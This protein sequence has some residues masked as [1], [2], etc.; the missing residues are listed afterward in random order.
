MRGSA[1]AALMVV[2]G[3]AG[4]E[5]KPAEVA[6]GPQ[7]AGRAAAVLPTPAA[8]PA[9]ASPAPP[10]EKKPVVARPKAVPDTAPAL[11]SRVA[12]KDTEIGRLLD[13]QDMILALRA[14]RQAMDAGRAEWRNPDNGRRGEIVVGRQLMVNGDD[15]RAYSHTIFADSRKATVESSACRRDGRWNIEG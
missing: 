11:P 7:E 9:K 15:C 8:P 13:Q 2:V 1:I 14:E 5:S 12:L 10:V 6:A 4:G 3:L